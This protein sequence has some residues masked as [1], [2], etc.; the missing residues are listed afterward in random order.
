MEKKRG[1]KST[2]QD[3]ALKIIKMP[4]KPRAPKVLSDEEEKVWVSVIDV[5]EQAWLSQ[6]QTPVLVQYCRHTIAAQ[7]ISQ[8]IHNKEEAKTVDVKDYI[9]LL[10]AQE[11]ESRAITA[12][13]RSLRI[14]NQSRYQSNNAQLRPDDGDPKPWDPV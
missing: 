7:R 4:D 9:E 14:T 11:R 2:G 13:A 1:R 8:L 3:V 6:D 12:L 10:K 5:H